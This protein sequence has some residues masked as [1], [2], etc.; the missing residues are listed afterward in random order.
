MKI[1]SYQIVAI[2]GSLLL[3][4]AGVLR[5]AHSGSPKELVP[6]DGG[7]HSLTVPEDREQAIQKSALWFQL[8]L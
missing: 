7:D 4:A 8:Y 6:I 1:Y 2:L 5:M 3:M